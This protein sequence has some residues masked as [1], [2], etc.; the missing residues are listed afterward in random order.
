VYTQI[1][2]D[3]KLPRLL[4]RLSKSHRQY[5]RS[6]C[7]FRSNDANSGNVLSK[8]ERIGCAQHNYLL[9]PLTLFIGGDL[10]GN[11]SESSKAILTN[12]FEEIMVKFGGDEVHIRSVSLIFTDYGEENSHLSHSNSGFRTICNAMLIELFSNKPKASLYETFTKAMNEGST[13]LIA[14][15]R[16][17]GNTYFSGVTNTSIAFDVMDSQIYPSSSPRRIDNFGLT[18]T[19][20]STSGSPALI[21]PVYTFESVEELHQHHF[22]ENSLASLSLALSTEETSIPSFNRKNSVNPS[23]YPPVKVITPPQ[24]SND[25]IPDEKPSVGPTSFYQTSKQIQ[26]KKPTSKGK[27]SHMFSYSNKKA[28]DQQSQH[29]SN[30]KYPTLYPHASWSLSCC[31]SKHQ[32]DQ[33]N[34]NNISSSPS[35]IVT[36]PSNISN[37]IITKEKPSSLMTSFAPTLNQKKSKKATTEGKK[38]LMPSQ[39]HVEPSAISPTQISNDVIYEEPSSEST[40]FISLLPTPQEKK[41]PMPAPLNVEPS[42]TSLPKISNDNIDNSDEPSSEPTSFIIPTIQENESS[43]PSHLHVEPSITSWPKISNDMIDNGDEP[44]SEPTS[45]VIPTIQENESS[46]PSRLHLEPSISSL[47]KI[48]NDIIDSSDEPSSEPIFYVF[49]T[50][51]GKE[52]SM[53][54]LSRNEPNGQM[55][56]LPSILTSPSILPSLHANDSSSLSSYSSGYHTDQPNQDTVPKS[57]TSTNMPSIRSVVTNLPHS[58]SK[59]PH[60]HHYHLHTESPS[61]P[62]PIPTSIMTATPSWSSQDKRLTLKPTNIETS[63]HSTSS[64]SD[65]RLTSPTLASV[66]TSSKPT[67]TSTEPDEYSIYAP[68][69]SLPTYPSNRPSVALNL[70]PIETITT[71][72]SNGPTAKP[73]PDHN[74]HHHHSE[75]PSES[76]VPSNAPSVL[77]SMYDVPSGAP[78]T[79]SQMPDLSPSFPSTSSLTSTAPSG[80]LYTMSPEH[81]TSST[82]GATLP[83]SKATVPSIL[84]TAIHSIPAVPSGSSGVLLSETIVPS[85]APS[86]I[87]LTSILSPN[88]PSF[89]HTMSPEL[90]LPSN[91]P[92]VTPSDSTLPSIMPSSTPSIRPSNAPTAIP[93]ESTIPSVAPSALPSYSSVPSG[94]PTAIPSDFNDLL[95]ESGI[96]SL[97]PTDFIPPTVAPSDTGFTYIAMDD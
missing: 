20:G 52:S 97:R 61:L 40:S 42:F 3:I 90:S 26:S 24:I 16:S 43:M 13:E 54:S 70:P 25:I 28:G 51:Q 63:V 4:R 76:V 56:N 48:S 18:P 89:T 47:Q 71:I 14:T 39:S 1:L 45:F 10:V 93:S 75:K 8:R 55:S 6:K 95:S 64:P 33:K 27:E 85:N 57:S 9:L 50:I 11:M 29:P 58:P 81:S 73:Q 2:N 5:R 46:M 49:P 67:A 87:P 59:I 62:V 21:A 72:P 12:H 34:N 23:S 77:P 92:I 78:T 17:S 66:V 30:S 94:A 74:H 15:L 91:A 38:T 68:S 82:S 65:M 96:P 41:L 84:P 32:K 19:L 31:P 36:F 86:V 83:S 69:I 22:G 88:D 37:H 80:S 35:T 60:H 53:P 44:S 7:Y 79:W